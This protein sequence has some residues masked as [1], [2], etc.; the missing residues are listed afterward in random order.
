MLEFGVTAHLVWLLKSLYDSAQGMIPLSPLLSLMCGEDIS[1]RVL[2]ELTERTGVII[3]GRAL[4]N[5]RYADDAALLASIRIHRN[6]F[7]VF[8]SC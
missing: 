4:W 8:S 6:K 3:G 7:T 2:V 5:L 1:K